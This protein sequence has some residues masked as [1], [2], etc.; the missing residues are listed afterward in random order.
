MELALKNNEFKIFL[1]PKYN[2]VQNKIVGAEALIRWQKNSKLILP[3]KFLPDAVKNN[4]ITKIDYFVFEN[5]CLLIKDWL[6]RNILPVPIS[7]NID[8]LDMYNDKFIESLNTTIKKYNVPIKYVELEIT[9]NATENFNLFSQAA[10]KLKNFGFKLSMDDF[11]SGYSS[12]SFLCD[13]PVDTLKLD[14][15]F[16]TAHKNINR[17]KIVIESIISM[18]KRLNINVIAEGVETQAQVD[19]LKSVGCEIIQ[20]YYFSPALTFKDFEKKLLEA[21]GDDKR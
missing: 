12:L 16:L 15:K 5:I 10:N 6:S 14:K 21:D 2:I 20:G 1:Q 4:F 13:I 8:K 3:D 18:A 7:I 9:E 11:G 17:C 19:F